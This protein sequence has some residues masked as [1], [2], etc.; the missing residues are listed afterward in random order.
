MVQNTSESSLAVETNVVYY[1]DD[2]LVSREIGHTLWHTPRL[3]VS[4]E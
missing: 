2:S 4:N 3:C 1:M